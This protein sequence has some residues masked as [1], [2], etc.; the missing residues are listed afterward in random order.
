M[1]F[2]LLCLL[3]LTLPAVDWQEVQ[4]QQLP[5]HIPADWIALASD[6][7]AVARWG[8]VAS[9]AQHIDQL[10]AALPLPRLAAVIRADDSTD[11]SDAVTSFRQRLHH[12]APQA[13]CTERSPL[14]QADQRWARLE[15]LLPRPESHVR[16]R[17]WLQRLPD[18]RLLV[19]A[20]HLDQVS[21]AW[22]QIF[23]TNLVWKRKTQY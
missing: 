19:V 8:V 13:T 23:E 6:S 14:Q 11:L 3:S 16:Q 7:P 22:L 17:L 15:I 1:R 5:L 12:V 4:H 9:D 18:D 20:L 21:A 2:G 10:T